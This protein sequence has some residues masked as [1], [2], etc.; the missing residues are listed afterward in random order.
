MLAPSFKFNLGLFKSNFSLLV[1]FLYSAWSKRARRRG[2]CWFSFHFAN[3]L[4]YRMVQQVVYWNWWFIFQYTENLQGAQLSLALATAAQWKY[5][6]YNN[7]NFIFS[8]KL[9]T[10]HNCKM[11]CVRK[12]LCALIMF[13]QSQMR[14]ILKGWGGGAPMSASKG[15]R[16][17]A[18][19]PWG[20]NPKVNPRIIINHN[21]C[22]HNFSKVFVDHFDYKI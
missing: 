11:V 21:R 18:N 5:Y 10:L 16:K 13:W 12:T 9:W 8:K 14:R 19:C 20:R 22:Y 3:Q 6:H 17:Y 15:I 4:I 1:L 2:A 7:N